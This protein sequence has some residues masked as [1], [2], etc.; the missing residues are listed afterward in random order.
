MLAVPGPG[1]ARGSR[2]SEIAHRGSTKVNN[3]RLAQL[4][5][6]AIGF[7]IVSAVAVAQH[8]Y[9]NLWRLIAQDSGTIQ[10]FCDLTVAMVLITTWMRRDARQSGVPALPYVLLTLAAGSFGPLGYLLHREWR[11]RRST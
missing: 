11:A 10:L 3:K 8:G 7:S 1:G 6:L 5:A 4:F 2:R 9:L